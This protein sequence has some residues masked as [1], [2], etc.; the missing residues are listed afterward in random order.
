MIRRHGRPGRL[1]GQR[2]GGRVPHQGRQAD[3]ERR[4]RHRWLPRQD[5]RLDEPRRL[6]R[7]RGRVAW[8]PAGRPRRAS[9]QRPSCPTARRSP[10]WPPLSR[11]QRWGRAR[12]RRGDQARR[13]HGSRRGRRLGGQA[14]WLGHRLHAE[15]N[16]AVDADPHVAEGHAVA[17]E[18][19]HRLLHHR[20][21]LSGARHTR[22]SSTGDRRGTPPHRLPQPRRPA[23]PLPLRPTESTTARPGEDA[24]DISRNRGYSASICFVH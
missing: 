7:C 5:R 3:R 19:S 20:G 14:R 12:G 13:S 6:G 2:G 21:Y 8:L 1:R 11:G 18:V 15:V 16:V 23:H 24:L 9:V 10:G 17:R 22:R 4:S